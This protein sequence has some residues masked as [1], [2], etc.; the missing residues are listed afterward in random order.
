MKARTLSL[1]V[2]SLFVA[3]V[4]AQEIIIKPT[5]KGFQPFSRV[6][7]S[8]SS[9]TGTP[10][11]L[12]ASATSRFRDRN[13]RKRAL[14]DLQKFED[15]SLFVGSMLAPLVIEGPLG[16]VAAAVMGGVLFFSHSRSSI[17]DPVDIYNAIYGDIQTQ[18]QQTINA[19]ATS[20]LT[21]SLFTLTSNLNNVMVG[22][23]SQLGMPATNLASTLQAMANGTVPIPTVSSE[24]VESKMSEMQGIL[25]GNTDWFDQGNVGMPSSSR[26]NFI[27][28]NAQ[29]V[30]AGGSNMC[31]H[32]KGHNIADGSEV[33]VDKDCDLNVVD[34]KLVTIDASTNRLYFRT[35]QGDKCMAYQ[36]KD[37]KGFEGNSLALYSL[38]SP[39]CSQTTGH[40]ITLKQI[41]ISSQTSELMW[42]FFDGP[43]LI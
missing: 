3:G 13:P 39:Q 23:L 35:S 27:F 8:S 22:Y 1:L 19:D 2:M 24:I 10:S 26:P 6:P 41:P 11:Q 29:G 34:D 32:T 9:S 16:V 20:K 33:V 36:S 38:S 28:T 25:S 21:S 14:T 42:A 43:V 7:K 15:G 4:Y 17:L 5:D 18:I 40:V 12:L 31:L 37:G 30:S